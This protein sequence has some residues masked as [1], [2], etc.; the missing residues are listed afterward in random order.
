MHYEHRAGHTTRSIT[1][2]THSKNTRHYKTDN[3]LQ[4]STIYT[5][6]KGNR[7]DIVSRRLGA[8]R[9]R[10]LQQNITLLLELTAHHRLIIRVEAH[11][12][13]SPHA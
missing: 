7:D 5:L 3:G 8:D 13:L 4:H 12:A 1:F 2:K 6:Q 11:M 9:I 10:S